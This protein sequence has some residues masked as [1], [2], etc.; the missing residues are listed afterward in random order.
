MAAADAPLLVTAS[1]DVPASEEDRVLVGRLLRKDEAAFLSLVDRL[2]GPMIRIAQSMVPSRAVAEEVVQETWQAVITG[3]A[4]FEGRSALRTWIFRILVK[5]A[6]TRGVREHRSIP[7]ASFGDAGDGANAPLRAI[8]GGRT[9][10]ALPATELTPERALLDGELRSQ[11]EAAIEAL[12]DSLREVLTMR[13][14]AGCSSDEV[15]NVLDIT[16]T[17]QRVMLHRARV[18]VRAALVEYLEGGPQTS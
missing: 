7:V 5:R 6:R 12:P 15:C 16:E 13:D 14:V 8:D 17:N 10:P 11:L 18:K 1:P 3:L 2:H 4:S 9:R